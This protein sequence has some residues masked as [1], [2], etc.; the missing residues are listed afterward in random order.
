MSPSALHYNINPPGKLYVAVHP[1]RNRKGSGGFRDFCA[2]PPAGAEHRPPPFIRK[3]R[4]GPPWR[5][6]R[7]AP[8]DIPAW[9][10]TTSA[11]ARWQGAPRSSRPTKER[12]GRPHVAVRQC[13]PPQGEAF[14]V[15]PHE[16]HHV[17][18]GLPDAPPQ[19]SPPQGGR[20]PAGPDEGAVSRTGHRPRG[21]PH[22]SRLAARQ[23]PRKG[24]AKAGRTLGALTAIQD[25]LSS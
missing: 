24:G 18:R 15:A 3:G 4:H 22:P 1:L 13:L 14:C 6:E 25:R 16:T 23:L 12:Q 21:H 11:G 8:M 9:C 17:G 20:W 5:G 19:P 10:L 7:T 2:P